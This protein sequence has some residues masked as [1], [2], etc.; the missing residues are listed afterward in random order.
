M[1]F[2]DFGNMV[3]WTVVITFFVFAIFT[4]FVKTS[5]HSDESNVIEVLL[6]K[7][8]DT[9]MTNIDTNIDQD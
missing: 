1:I 6:Y 8:I 4:K 9:L 2:R 7:N 5:L 3:F